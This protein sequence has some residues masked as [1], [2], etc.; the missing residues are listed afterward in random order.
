MQKVKYGGKAGA[1]DKTR[2]RYNA[3]IDIDGIPEEAQRY[4]LGSRSALDW[5]I[6][7][8]QIKTDKASGIVNDPNDWSREHGQPR[9]IIDLIGRIVTVSVETMRIVDA[10][11]ELGL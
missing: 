8:Y 3:F 1:Y 7:R 6:E 4:M 9:Y 2:I 11:P 10:L 5:I